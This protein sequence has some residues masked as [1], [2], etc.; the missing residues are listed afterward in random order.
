MKRLFIALLPRISLGLTGWRS[1]L[2]V[3]RRIR[4]RRR[5]RRQR[6]SALAGL[7]DLDGCLTGVPRLG[8][9]THLALPRRGT[10]AAEEKRQEHPHD[11]QSKREDVPP[12]QALALRRIR[13]DKVSGTGILVGLIGTYERGLQHYGL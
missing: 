8:P 5:L 13:I 4:P 9:D 2:R 3:R 12:G 1:G 6:I 11:R 10:P 7:A